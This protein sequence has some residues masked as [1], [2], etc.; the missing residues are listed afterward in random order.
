MQR[1][2]ILLFLLFS[3]SVSFAYDELRLI[4]EDGYVSI[5]TDECTIP[6]AKE[7]GL[8]K[9]AIGYDTANGTKHEGCWNSPDISEAK[10]P[11]PRIKIVPIVNLYF[12]G[13][14]HSTPLSIWSLP[15]SHKNPAEGETWL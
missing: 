10:S 15:P 5:T 1:L 8:T 14:I 4:L 11:D 9:R 3:S 6:E 7:K 2:L 13:K 12:D